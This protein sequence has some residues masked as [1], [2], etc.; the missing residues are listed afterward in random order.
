MTLL[1]REPRTSAPAGAFDRRLIPPMILGSLLNPVNSSML[2]VALI[3]I[4]LALGAPPSDT[5][6]LVSALYLATAVGQPVVGRLVDAY[7]PRPLYLTGAALVG[8]AGALGAV[9]PNLPVLVVARVLIG[10]GTCAGYPAAMYL[11]RSEGQ[12][13]G[14]NS[15]SGVL[16]ALS[17]ATQVTAVIGPT[18]GGLLIGVGGWRTIFTVNVPLA[19]ASLVLGWR[20][21]PRAR[22]AADAEPSDADGAPSLA[23][24]ARLDVPGVVLFAATLTSAMLFLMDPQAAHA[25]LLVVAAAAGVG[26]VLRERRAADPFIDLRLLGGNR[27]LIATYLRQVLT[28]TVSYAFL[29]GYTQWLEAGRGLSAS[30]AGL[31]LLPMFVTGIV[32][33]STA[34]R[35]PKVRGKLVVGSLAQIAACLVLL[36]VVG[37]A[38][39]IWVLVLVAVVAGIPQGLNGLANQNALY[40]QA[41][42]ARIGSAAGL[43]RTF[44]YLGALAAAAANASFFAGGA[45]TAGLHE[46]SVFVMACAAAL[47]VLTLVDQSLGRIGVPSAPK[48]TS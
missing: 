45:D 29:Y 39:P 26:F 20:R 11:I 48:G 31:L 27:P 24:G 34:G 21:L 14:R 43:L 18:L 28:F 2:A 23:R 8:L 9:A 38:T 10:L 6:W 5:V 37:S 47:L 22:V 33:T 1:H 25:Y 13:T 41:D 46:L 35:R 44:T 36:L 7:G 40:H 42:P 3:P 17:V 4:G 16:A 19:A 15:P 30:A 32:A 12:R